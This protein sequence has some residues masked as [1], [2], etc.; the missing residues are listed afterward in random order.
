MLRTVL[1]NITVVM[2]LL[3]IACGYNKS[4]KTDYTIPKSLAHLPQNA[5]K[6]IKNKDIQLSLED[7]GLYKTKL[8][9]VT[10]IDPSECPIITQAIQG[11]VTDLTNQITELGLSGYQSLKVG[12]QLVND[13]WH[14]LNSTNTDLKTLLRHFINSTQA[15][16]T[17]NLEILS[18]ANKRQLAQLNS[19][20]TKAMPN[21]RYYYS[22]FDIETLSTLRELN[23]SVYLGLIWDPSHQSLAKMKDSLNNHQSF[24]LSDSYRQSLR[25]RQ[26][27][28]T[29]HL[30]AKKLK[31]TLGTNAGLHVD[32]RS[33]GKYPTILKRVR[34]QQLA[35]VATYS[36]NG[37][38]YHVKQLQS[39]R[40][41]RLPNIAISSASSFAMCS[42][43]NNKI[44]STGR[45]G[46]L[47]TSTAGSLIK[48]LPADANFE[49]LAEQES[50]YI[51]GL[52][53]NALGIV[54]SLASATSPQQKI[55]RQHVEGPKAVP[56]DRGMNNTVK[57]IVISV[58]ESNQ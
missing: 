6:T 19:M 15:D 50:Y 7:R 35:N 37:P 8:G 28:K 2:L 48:A 49:K 22:A 20:T 5:E 1:F 3:L 43:T 58:P 57:P 9:T 4:D 39:L 55:S 25:N 42:A 27:K 40:R 44:A 52:Y 16:Q 34:Q 26:T 38:I 45:T 41:N 12:I 13:R 11:D 24:F 29:Y 17:L 18:N 51:E 53:L 32:I 46:Y 54:R 31:T 56:K 21:R 30:S 36:I 47:P 23:I 33:Y 14:I 10:L